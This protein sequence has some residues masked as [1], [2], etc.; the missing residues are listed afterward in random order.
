MLQLFKSL[1]IKHNS[2]LQLNEFSNHKFLF[3]RQLYGCTPHNTNRVAT[4]QQEYEHQ[5]VNFWQEVPEKV[6]NNY[7]FFEMFMEQL[8]LGI[9]CFM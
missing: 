7:F 5:Q 1:N 6:W 9:A 4:C 3:F 2:V 8:I